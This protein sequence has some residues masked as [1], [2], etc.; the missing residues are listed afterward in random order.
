MGGAALL[1]P[2]PLNNCRQET[3]VQVSPNP[4]PPPI[5][6]PLEWAFLGSTLLPH[7]NAFVSHLRDTA[8]QPVHS[9]GED[10]CTGQTPCTPSLHH[11]SESAQRTPVT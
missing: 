5:P 7:H 1:Q 11:S 4:S 6:P 3:L 10:L 2:R 8:V 9:Y